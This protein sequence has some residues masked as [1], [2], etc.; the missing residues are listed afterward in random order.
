MIEAGK[1]RGITPA[2]MLALDLARIEAGYPLIEV[3]FISAEKALI[4]SQKSSPYE[5][6]LGWAVN[7]KKPY[8]IGRQALE[9]EKKRGPALSFVGLEI[10]WA[11]IGRMFSEVD[12]IPQLPNVASRNPVPVYAGERQ[13]LL[14]PDLET[15]V[16]RITRPAKEHR[17]AAELRFGDPEILEPRKIGARNFHKDL[18]RTRT[19]KSKCPHPLREIFYLHIHRLRVRFE[20]T[21]SGIGGGG[22]E[23]RL[24]QTLK[25]TVL[26]NL[27][28]SIA[29]WNVEDL[30]D[31]GLGRVPG[32]EAVDEFFGV[33]ASNLIF[34][35]RGNIDERRT[36][37]YGMVL[38]LMKIVVRAHGEVAG[39]LTPVHAGTEY[40]P[41][42]MKRCSYRHGRAI[43]FDP[44][45]SR[46]ERHRRT[47]CLSPTTS[48]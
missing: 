1:G 41:P 27:S 39:P 18:P 14:N 42:R 21:Q 24:T 46:N 10:Q 4:E 38:R 23:G 30:A 45:P 16:T 8:F 12:L 20:P 36:V 44:M 34:E 26:N 25:R 43:L 32:N 31:L 3:D 15:Q 11:E 47:I 29:P 37:S 35:K 22:A 2:G 33:S 17:H 40:R 19:L 7:F 28:L 6:G 9:E 13:I 5:I 48:S